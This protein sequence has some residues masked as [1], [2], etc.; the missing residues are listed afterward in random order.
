MYSIKS[1]ENL[2]AKEIFLIHFD[3]FWTLMRKEDEIVERVLN[4]LT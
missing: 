4:A 2:L 3:L 1:K